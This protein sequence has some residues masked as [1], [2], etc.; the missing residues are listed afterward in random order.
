SCEIFYEDHG[1]IGSGSGIHGF[2]T[3]RLNRFSPP[4]F[5]ENPETSPGLFAPS[6]ER[7]YDEFRFKNIG[8]QTNCV[9]AH[10][11][12]DCGA[13]NYFVVAYKNF[14]DPTNIETNYLADPGSSAAPGR[15]FSFPVEAG[16]DFS[17]VLHD[18]NPGATCEAY[19]LRLCS[20]YCTDVAV[21]KTADATD[22]PIGSSVTYNLRVTNN[23][24]DDATQ[25]TGNDPVPTGFSVTGTST[26]QGSVSAV[27]NNVSF[28]LGALALGES[29]DVTV[30]AT[31]VSEGVQINSAT[32]RGTGFDIDANSNESSVLV[33]TGTDGDGDGQVSGSDN[34][35]TVGNP[36]QEDSD[37]DGLGNA[38]DNCPSVANGNQ[39]NLDGDSAGDAC[40]TCPADPLK[41]APGVCGCGVPDVDANQNGILDCNSTLELN[42]FLQALQKDIKKLKSGGAKKKLR[43]RKKAIRTGLASV[44][45]ILQVSVDSVQTTNANVNL[46]KLNNQMR[47]AVRGATKQLSASAKRKAL[48]K[49]KK[50]QKSLIVS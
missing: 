13:G 33:A 45:S 24:P 15:L 6:G 14:F 31:A 39:A 9:S 42:S 37:G 48:A 4:G 20:N 3:G 41:L 23:G 40:E 2:Q 47:K 26:T 36:G 49:V 11:L 27:G 18:L 29:A 16:Q 1:P 8:L 25:V 21:E 38:C 10:V 30:T 46:T 19:S 5:C 34:C 17:L 12:D 35:P 44:N 7:A 43:Q 50:F 32:V 22:T 28:S